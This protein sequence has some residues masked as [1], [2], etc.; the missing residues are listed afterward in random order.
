MRRFGN[1]LQASLVR[2]VV[3]LIILQAINTLV[4]TTMGGIMAVIAGIVTVLLIIW[5]TT[6]YVGRD[7]R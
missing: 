1:W 6:L 5:L 2:F 3:L 7:S 4:L